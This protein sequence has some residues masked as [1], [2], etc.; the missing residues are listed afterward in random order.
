MD[1]SRPTLLQKRAASTL[2]RTLSKK[3]QKGKSTR[4]LYVSNLHDSSE[5]NS[6]AN[7]SSAQPSPMNTLLASDPQAVQRKKS[8]SKMERRASRKPPRLSL[9]SS[10]L[11]VG[12]HEDMDENE[13]EENGASAF[14]LNTE[15]GPLHA[16]S[17]SEEDESQDNGILMGEKEKINDIKLV[18][19]MGKK[20]EEQRMP[21]E[22]KYEEVIE[23]ESS[24]S[25][26]DVKLSDT[27]KGKV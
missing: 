3:K 18:S 2:T 12:E 10:S 19:A 20:E 6:T 15:G 8:D 5:K 7:G 4:E 22:H 17:S 11:F 9:A 23:V 24:D 1:F 16:M 21:K 26:E 14:V 13:D 25:D 27:G